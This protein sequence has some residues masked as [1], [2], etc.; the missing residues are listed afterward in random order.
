[1]TAPARCGIAGCK[2]PPMV[3]QV[4][5]IEHK[6]KPLTLKQSIAAGPKFE[7]TWPGNGVMCSACGDG[8]KDP[9]N[10]DAT[11]GLGIRCWRAWR[12]SMEPKREYG[13]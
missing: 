6:R 11:T 10:V 8:E 3:G 2:L 1:M 12:F 7:S 9:G 13:G 4:V 5:C